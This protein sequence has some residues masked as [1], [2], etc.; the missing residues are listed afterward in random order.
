MPL[1]GFDAYAAILTSRIQNFSDFLGTFSELMMDGR[2]WAGD[3]Y[4]PVG[5]LFLAV[6]YAI[7]GIEPFG[8]Q[9]SNM[10]LWC[11]TIVALFALCRRLLGAPVWIGPC[12]AALFFAL[13]PATLSIL[14]FLARRTETLMVLFVALCLVA[15]PRDGAGRLERRHWIAGLFALAAVGSKETGIIAVPLVFTHQFLL[16]RNS[17]RTSLALR[18]RLSLVAAI[19]AALLSAAL[20]GARFFVIGGLGGYHIGSNEPY[21]TKLSQFALHYL[22]ATFVSGG[23]DVP[24][25]ARY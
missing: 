20:L 4:R 24:G 15:L 1:F 5:N 21:L 3:F 23:F 2:L 10:L 22:S 6:D 14:P 16:A 13:H 9:L 25:G 17:S 19:P 8:Y 12:L 7:W 18:F 11:A